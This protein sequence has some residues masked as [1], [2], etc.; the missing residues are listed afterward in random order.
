M[1]LVGNE[2]M[3]EILA[4]DDLDV[5]GGGGQR[6]PSSQDKRMVSAWPEGAPWKE[7]GRDLPWVSLRTDRAE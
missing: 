1:G 3:G 7:E 2:G 4:M 5:G 6:S